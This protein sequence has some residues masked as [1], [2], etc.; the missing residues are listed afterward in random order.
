MKTMIEQQLVAA[1]RKRFS[2]ST[3]IVDNEYE[4]SLVVN[5]ILSGEV[6]FQHKTDLEP[7]IQIITKRIEESSKDKK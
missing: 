2:I 4:T 5:S 6:I 3:E 1:L 7:L